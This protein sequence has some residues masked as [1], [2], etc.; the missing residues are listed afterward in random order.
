V[1]EQQRIA[2]PE[3]GVAEIDTVKGKSHV[4]NSLAEVR[5]SSAK[6]ARLT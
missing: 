2:A 4:A 3:I 5:R 6:A 1:N